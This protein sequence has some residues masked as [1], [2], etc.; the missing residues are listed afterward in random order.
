MNT[1][2]II[3]LGDK[4]LMRNV[5]RLQLAPV[6]GEGA[7]MWDADR[8]EYLD[9][10]SGIAVNNLGHCHPEVVDAISQQAKKLIHCSNLYY[11]EPQALLAKLLAENSA[12]DKAFFCNSGAEANEAAIKL[13]RKYA[14]I[15]HGTEKV[16]IV[17]ALNSFHG[18]TL[19]AITATGQP[20]YQKGFEPLPGGFKYVPFND[21]DTLEQAVGPATCA[22]MLEPVQGEGGV[23]VASRY[24]LEGVKMLCQEH[25]ALL[26]FDEVQTGLGRT[27]RFLA[28]QHYGVEP[29]IIT[30]AKA[31]GGGFPIG[32]MLAT[33][34]VAAAFQPGDHA[35]TF[36]GNPLAC[37]A[38][39]A[40]MDLLLTGGV[41]ENAAAVGAYM[42]DKLVELAGKYDYVKEVRGLGLLLGIELKI[43]GKD[44]VNGCREKGLLI[45]CVNNNVLRFIPPLTITKQ[46]VDHAVGILEGVM[47]NCSV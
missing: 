19:A 40:A 27:G 10:V 32:A 8:K 34:E 13:A 35:S 16:E 9:F 25:G 31:L 2:E 11:I 29:D 37:A 42:Y 39:L 4:Y 28:Y 36:G 24:Y 30:L 1:K 14:K 6:K 47:G 15:K 38:A 20:K 17:T 12:M 33:D 44:I 18:R 23:N 22:V 5:G 41:V 26:I 45:N 3:E 7:L 43:E 46:D 21:L